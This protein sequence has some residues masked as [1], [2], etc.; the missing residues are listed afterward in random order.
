M[1]NDVIHTLG[2]LV[3]MPSG[4]NKTVSNHGWDTKKAYYHFFSLKGKD[5]LDKELQSDK[6]IGNMLSKK[7]K[8]AILNSACLP[9]L[10]NVSKVET[11]TKDIIRER[12]E[13]IA[14]IV[15]DKISSWLWSE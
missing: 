3:L 14:E 7:R 9:S 10:Q 11:W 2:N 8:D 4:E 13:N 15:F 5:E 6:T 1:D 12:G